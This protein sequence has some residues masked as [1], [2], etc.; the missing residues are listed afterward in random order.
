MVEIC[1]LGGGSGSF[2]WWWLPR[3]HLCP[4]PHA[5]PSDS[6]T[7]TKQSGRYLKHPAWPEYGF[8]FFFF[9]CYQRAMI[10][11]EVHD[12]LLGGSWVAAAPAFRGDGVLPGAV[13]ALFS[14][15]GGHT[16]P[17]TWLECVQGVE[18]GGTGVTG[19]YQITVGQR[20]I[21][22][23]GNKTCLTD[24]VVVHRAGRRWR[25]E[26]DT[27]DPAVETRPARSSELTLGSFLVSLALLP[28]NNPVVGCHQV[29]VWS[30][31]SQSE[32]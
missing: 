12:D 26:R 4:G 17:W 6:W 2:M 29:W 14:Q 27:A 9:F 20:A 5:P 24:E 28:N 7:E 21:L 25:G 22:L 8:F 19:R 13:R 1:R 32:V 23:S 31:K 30:K 15:I 16:A 10:L 18:N 3:G 11:I